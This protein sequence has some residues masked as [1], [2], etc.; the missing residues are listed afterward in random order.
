MKFLSDSL[1]ISGN[2]SEIETFDLANII[3]KNMKICDVITL[4]GEIGAGKTHLVRNIIQALLSEKTTITSP[5][6]TLVQCYNVANIPL[7]HFDLYR[8]HS[9]SELENLGLEESLNSAITIIE[10][11]EIAELYLN[12]TPRLHIKIS[13]IPAQPN[14]RNYQFYAEQSWQERIGK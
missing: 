3:A 4:E 10:W 5:T 13:E 11:P 9:E 8:L 14:L 7:W 2:Y 12:K 6:F 1:S